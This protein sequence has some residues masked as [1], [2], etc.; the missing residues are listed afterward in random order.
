MRANCRKAGREGKGGEKRNRVVRRLSYGEW[1]TRS[2][3]GVMSG[4]GIIFV[5]SLK[6][7]DIAASKGLFGF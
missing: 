6:T 2:T 1:F 3:P 4:N 5:V 7:I